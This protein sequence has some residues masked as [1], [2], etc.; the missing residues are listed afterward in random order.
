MVSTD[1][2]RNSKG[3]PERLAQ[4]NASNAVMPYTATVIHPTTVGSPI[5]ACQ[6]PSKS[7]AIGNHHYGERPL[8]S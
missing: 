3:S 6:R 5:P 7:T 8:W 1:Q 4:R 2:N